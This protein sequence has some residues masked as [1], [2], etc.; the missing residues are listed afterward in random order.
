MLSSSL[1]DSIDEEFRKTFPNE[2]E[3]GP[4]NGVINKF[5]VNTQRLTEMNKAVELQLI[6]LKTEEDKIK[7]KLNKTIRE[8][9]KTI[10]NGL[11]EKIEETMQECY[12]KAADC[13]GQGS[14]QRMRDALQIHVHV[15]KN[16]MF[17]EAKAA[18]LTQ[19]NELKEEIR[20]DLEKTLTEAV[21]LSL[22]TDDDSIPD[23]SEEL[24]RVK[25]YLK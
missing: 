14:L 7:T 24:E 17:E 15:S 21:E 1:T 12:K 22:K 20:D 10:Y 6:F 25:E 2:A 11:E 13:R 5:S 23:V 9:K 19:L 8:R 16:T 18:M 3:R 4:F